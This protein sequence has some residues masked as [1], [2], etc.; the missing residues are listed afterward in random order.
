MCAFCFTPSPPLAQFPAHYH[1][2]AS[3][4]IKISTIRPSQWPRQSVSD[5]HH[6]VHS[7]RLTHP[8]SPCDT[9]FPI[10]LCCVFPSL[11]PYRYL[12]I[13]TRRWVGLAIHLRK[14]THCFALSLC[15][16]DIEMITKE[17]PMAITE[18]FWFRKNTQEICKLWP[19]TNTRCQNTFTPPRMLLC[20][21]TV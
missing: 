20:L 17:D 9:P 8:C 21:Y 3:H 1:P 6:P 12:S 18:I 2:T 7:A 4:C 11:D 16:L 5:Q 19:P 14:V 10:E 15:Y 13:A